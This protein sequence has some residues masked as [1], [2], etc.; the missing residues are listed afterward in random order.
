[1]AAARRDGRTGG[2]WSRIGPP[3]RGQTGRHGG[4][5]EDDQPDGDR[6]GHHERIEP[7]TGIRSLAGQGR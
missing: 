5:R 4:N 1:M 6:T 2:T 7:G 3:S